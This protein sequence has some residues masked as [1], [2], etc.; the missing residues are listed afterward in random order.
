L[1]SQII[2]WPGLLTCNPFHKV[3]AFP[4]YTLAGI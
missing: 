3:I 1:H 2:P 4:N